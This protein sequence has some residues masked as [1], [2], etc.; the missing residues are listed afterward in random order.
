MDINQFQDEVLAIGNPVNNIDDLGPLIE[1]IK[2]KKI[3]MLG[4]SS[5]GT[6]DF[7]RWR[8]IISHEL[9]TKF[10]FN[11]IAVEGDW[12]ACE[13]INK[14]IQEGSKTDTMTTINSFS[15][16]PTWMWAN[17]EILNLMDDL[18]DWNEH[19]E[20]SVGFHG[21]D[22]YSLYESLDEVLSILR[23]LDPKFGEEIKAYYTCFDPYRHDEK[24]YARSLVHHNPGCKQEVATALQ[25]ILE[26][27]LSDGSKVMNAVQNA[28]IIQNGEHYYHVMMSMEEDSWNVRDRHMMETL[29]MLLNYYGAQSK[30]IVWAHNTHIGDYRATDMVNYGQ[31]N[32]GGLARQEYGGDK[33]ALVGFTTYQGEV[34]ASHAWDGPT[35]VMNVP[36]AKAESLESY[37]HSCVGLME[38]ENFYLDFSDLNINSEFYNLTSHRAIG[39]V[40]DPERERRGNYVP[41]IPGKRY[42]ALF[43]INRS[44]A[45]TP[46]EVKFQ[47]DK[48]PETYPYGSRI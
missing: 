23:T 26:K 45:L 37:L 29:S 30:A 10:G 41:T 3:V 2:D 38:N 28:R 33:V 5:H 35:E 27:K 17:T 22:V 20:F 15:R 1:K 40:Y 39:V 34:I 25:K 43:F 21:L 36:S 48:M 47:P 6:E 19:S 32:I 24:A 18:R 11:F 14:F 31:I 7:Y 16:W 9:I 12:P 46:L 13:R 4:E 8:R 42:D 44:E